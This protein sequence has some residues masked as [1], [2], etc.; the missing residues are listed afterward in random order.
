MMGG[1]H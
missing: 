1:A